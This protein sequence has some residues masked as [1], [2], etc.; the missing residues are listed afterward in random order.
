MVTVRS[1][2]AFV[3]QVLVWAVLLLVCGLLVVGVLLPRVGGATP[4]TVLTGSMSPHYPPGTLVVSRPLDVDDVRVGDVVTYQLRSGEAVTVTHR[5]IASRLRPDGQ[6][7]LITQGD[8]NSVPDAAPV[9]G[10][11][12][13]GR[14]W[15]A[16]PHLGRANALMSG[17]QR[18]LAVYAVAGGLSLYA[19]AMFTAAGRER[20]RRASP[21]R[22]RQHAAA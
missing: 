5:V 15:Y 11:Q 7:E 9:A 10:V 22:S 21:V 6:R 18:Q 12:L 20:R 3:T 2:T 19:A 8:A 13:R 17:H 14:L 1:S 16:V 4:Y